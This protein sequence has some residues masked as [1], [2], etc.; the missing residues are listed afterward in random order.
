[1]LK[2]NI[3]LFYIIFIGFFLRLYYLLTKSG[4]LFLPNL[5]GDSC[6]HY[7][8][9]LNI[10][11]WQGPKTDFIFSYW[12]LHPSIPAYVD[13]Y[14]PG[15]SAFLSIFL[16]FNDNFFNLRVASFI[17]GICSIFLAY[18]IGR[19][20]YSKQLGLI[21]AFFIAVN[22]FHIENSTVVMRE[23][24]TLIL[25][26]IFFLIL[27]Y[28]NNK[29]KLMIFL[30]GLLSGYIS[31][32]TGIWPLYVVIYFI[33]IL[34]ELK[35][36]PLKFF[37][38]YSLG[39]FITSFL[40][41][42]ITKSYFGKFYYSNLN[43]YPYVNHWAQMMF[44]RGLPNVDQFWREINLY[45]YFYK[46]FFWFIKNLYLGSLI[47]IPTFIFFLFFLFIPI[48]FFGAYKLRFRGY[49]LILFSFIY[50]LGLSYGSYALNG[51]L[52]PRHFLPLLSSFVLLFG[53][54]LIPY[55]NYIKKK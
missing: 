38:I 45:E 30:I 10:A 37:I 24:F 25:S 36:I 1:M 40:W 44:D 47:L 53:A 12:F 39:F 35:K 2:K 27:F 33:Y 15:Y 9:A 29:S 50:L 32:T 16:F 5:G 11:N 43:Y 42:Y 55:F 21:S 54:G 26:Q 19:K 48:S 23:I 17:I 49:I 13:L 51:K 7:N 4:N 6:Y 3:F 8:V 18:F 34:I 41:L 31:I 14:G 52:A 28:T 20:I 46:H 22:F